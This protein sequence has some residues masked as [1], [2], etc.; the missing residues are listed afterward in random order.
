MKDREEKAVWQTQNACYSS[1]RK[2]A[3][4]AKLS[5]THLHLELNKQQVQKVCNLY[6]W[7]EKSNGLESRNTEIGKD[8]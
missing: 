7:E 8:H 5:L 1:A 4:I 3:D 6:R 2:A